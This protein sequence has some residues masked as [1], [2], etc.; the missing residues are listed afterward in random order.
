M[1]SIT[2]T[3]NNHQ[4]EHGTTKS[5]IVGFILSLVFT[6]IPYYLVVE[7]VITGT[8]L[9][10]TILGF[11]VL[12]MLVQIIFFLHLGREKGPRWQLAFFVSTVGIILVVVVG[13]LWIMSHL[14]YNMT[15]VT[16]ED[17]SKKLVEK[18]GISQIGGAKTGACKGEHVNHKVVIKDGQVSPALTEAR[19][20]DSLTFINEDGQ[21][22]EMTFGTHP[23]HGVYGGDSELPV[24][25]GRAKSIILTETGTYMF[26]D[27][28]NPDVSGH[29]TVMP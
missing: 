16:R 28:M 3:T 6:F 1:S 23:N 4:S 9:L 25:K 10:V 20:C 14:H 22:R 12:Q 13:S 5:Y 11:A 24:R 15:P 17:A 19:K 7:K 8:G 29:F 2:H 27:H 21:V 18:E 26:H